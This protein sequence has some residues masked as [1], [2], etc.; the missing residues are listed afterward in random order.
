[1]F[2]LGNDIL[3]RM[4]QHFLEW[5]LIDGWS[6][7]MTLTTCKRQQTIS[8]LSIISWAHAPIFIHMRQKCQINRTC[9]KKIIFADEANWWMPLV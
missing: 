9:D 7:G 1:M 3:M 5:S 6:N 2:P 4:C 8:F